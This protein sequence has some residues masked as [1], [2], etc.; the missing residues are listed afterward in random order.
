[1]WSITFNYEIWLTIKLYSLPHML[2]TVAVCI[3]KSCVYCAVLQHNIHV[4]TIIALKSVPTNMETIMAVT[5]ILIM[6]TFR[7]LLFL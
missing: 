5:N 3:Y 1:M 4:A 7:F 2:D 6:F